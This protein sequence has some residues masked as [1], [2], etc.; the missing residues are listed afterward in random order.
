MPERMKV[1]AKRRQNEQLN[2]QLNRP[3][4]GHWIK[5]WIELLKHGTKGFDNF[6]FENSTEKAWQ[7]AGIRVM[8]ISLLLKSGWKDRGRCMLRRIYLRDGLPCR[9]IVSAVVPGGIPA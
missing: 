3:L 4:N 6:N 5:H 8:D 2:E 9:I 1:H 7:W